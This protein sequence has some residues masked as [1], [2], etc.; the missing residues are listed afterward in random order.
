MQ[1]DDQVE[2]LYGKP[3]PVVA[4]PPPAAHTSSIPD[5]LDGPGE[6]PVTEEAGHIRAMAER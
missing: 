4:P 1:P 2:I 3:A 6:Q 5:T